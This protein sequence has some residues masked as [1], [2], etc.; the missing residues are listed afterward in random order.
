[1]MPAASGT[2]STAWPSLVRMIAAARL[3]VATLSDQPSTKPILSAALVWAKAIG[4]EAASAAMPR[5]WVRN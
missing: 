1:M 4:P 5:D 3:V 2:S